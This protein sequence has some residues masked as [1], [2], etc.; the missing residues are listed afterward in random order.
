MELW[1]A[2]HGLK[3]VHKSLH[4]G[5]LRLSERRALEQKFKQLLI[6]KHDRY[7]VLALCGSCLKLFGSTYEIP[8][9]GKP[10]EMV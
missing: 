10:Y 1:C 5:F 4:V 8:E 9:V 3:Q 6:G 7:C 2:D